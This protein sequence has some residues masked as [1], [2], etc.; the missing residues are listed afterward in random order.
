MLSYVLLATLVQSWP[1]MFGALVWLLPLLVAGD[2]IRYGLIALVLGGTLGILMFAFWFSH[3]TASAT[4]AYAANAITASYIVPMCLFS[5]G[6]V[7]RLHL[8]EAVRSR[9][10]QSRF[11]STMSHEL[12]TP[13]NAIVGSA[14]LVDLDG[15]EGSNRRLFES[16]KVNADTLNRRVHEVL[17]ISAINAGHMH[18]VVEPFLVSTLMEAVTNACEWAANE[19][20]LTLRVDMRQTDVMVVGDVGRIEQVLINLTYN[21]I[22]FTSSGGYVL[23]RL[24]RRLGQQLGSMHLEVAVIDNGIG[25]DDAVKL[26]VFEPFH[27]LHAESSQHGVGLGLYIVKCITDAMGGTI[28]VEDN[29]GGGS[30]FTWAVE[31]PLATHD[32]SERAISL[33]RAIEVHRMKIPCMRCLVVED[34]DS[35]LEMIAHILD[36]AGHQLITARDGVEGI[37]AVRAGDVD[38]VFLDLHMPNANGWDVLDQLAVNPGVAALPPIAILSADSDAASIATATRLGVLAYLTKPV[39]TRKLLNVIELANTLKSTGKVPRTMSYSAP[40]GHGHDPLLLE[41]LRQL[42]PAISQR[43]L[44]AASL[45][46]LQTASE[47]LRAPRNASDDAVV[48]RQLHA[49][50]NEFKILSMHEGVHA[51]EMASQ[52]IR[53]GTS[54]EREIHLVLRTVDSAFSRLGAARVNDSGDPANG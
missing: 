18:L 9:D 5:I 54:G 14:Q 25:I 38:L 26:Q 16:I 36:R 52:V 27:Q 39:S 19:R 15:L 22:K 44:V 43:R 10:L 30:I 41:E 23:L 8:N 42:M 32:A 48:L 47:T 29:P 33:T 3:G 11:I 28:G 17:D 31:L 2:A 37:E 45:D 12:R 4:L 21:A 50:K 53:A 51:C 24:S 20:H 34:I 35:N 46:G 7:A 13:L 1:S 6:K 40:G 49:L